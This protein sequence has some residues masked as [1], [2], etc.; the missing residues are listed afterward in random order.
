M[1]RPD[2]RLLRRTR[3]ARVHLA[4]AVGLGLLTALLAIGQAGLIAIAIDGAFWRGATLG[5]LQAVIVA[6]AV[7][8][9]GRATVGWAQEVAAHRASASVKS[10]LR[11]DIVAAA[12]RRGADQTMEDR[13]ARVVTVATTGVDA[14]DVYYA[15]FIPQVV[16]AVILPLA[17]VIAI[18]PVDPIAAVTVAATVPLI[19]VFMA[20]VGKVAESRRRRRWSALARLSH[21]FLDVVAGLPT[22]KLFGRSRIQ[23]ERLAAT[24]DDYRRESLAAMRVAFLSALVL[25]LFATLAVALVAVG[26]GLRLVA[27]SMD[28]ATGLFVLVL[29]PE[30]YLPIRQLGVHY[31]ASEDGLVASEAAFEIIGDADASHPAAGAAGVLDAGGLHLDADVP[32]IRA[33]GGI[34]VER[35]S[36]QR[37]DRA[38]ATPDELSITVRAGEVVALTG[39][40]GSGK[41]S[42]LAAILGLVPISTGSIQAWGGTDG[43]SVDLRGLQPAA[44]RATV[45]WVPQLP[46]L[47]AGTVADNVRL[48]AADASDRQVLE[49]LAAVG[50]DDVDPA[51]RLGEHGTGLSSGEGRRLAVAR[52]LVRDARLLLLDEPTAGLDGD[53]ERQVLEAI[54]A[55]ARSRSAAVLLV[56]HRPAAIAAAD[57]VVRIAPVQEAAA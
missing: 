1:N 26:V 43:R 41:S 4:I 24:T 14:L 37:P 13:T 22:L 35:V 57:R 36:V 25:E 5:S 3:A 39:P 19:V 32:D 18:L 8:L 49:A 54:V 2:P 16:L 50:L 40:S 21:H 15:R 52:A 12:L 51:A 38:A 34:R 30:A 45:G 47:F 42:L 29:A 46:Y 31:H 27:G 53:S 11:R 48:G 9:L 23:V 20:L 56:A 17:V 44:W 33:G 6:L 7:V 10:A 55:V 28:Y